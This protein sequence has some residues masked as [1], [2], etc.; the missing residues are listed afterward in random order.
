MWFRELTGFAEGEVVDVAA[1]LVVDG[2]QMT[3]TVN[4]RRFRVGRF[5]TPTLDEL[6]QRS[7]AT[8]LSGSPVSS[9]SPG[10]SLREVV[11]DVGALHADPA[12]TGALFQVA[13]QFNTLEMIS[14]D[15]T[16]EDGVDRYESDRT[17]GPA[18]AVACG[19]G[20]IY[21]N[22][23]V[24]FDE[25]VGQTR[26]RQIDCLATLAQGLGVVVPMSNGYALP[27]AEL[28]D[29]VG[30]LLGSCSVAD[31]DALLG[32]LRIGLQWDTEVTRTVDGGHV[33]HAV[34]QAYCSAMPVAY[35]QHGAD[36][37]EPF[38]RLV[39]DAAYEATFHAALVNGARTGNRTLYLTM[40][41]GGVFGNDPRWILDAIERATE[42]LA[43]A[44]ALDVAIVS[45]GSPN[46]QLAPL[47]DRSG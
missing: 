44:A 45:H 24:P 17:Q 30:G 26:D 34:S 7:A 41:G 39:L 46:T 6:R 38:A 27:S 29:E 43:G 1:N 12:N 8:E 18:C 16:P 3:S 5:E 23:L 13:S 42:T 2:H 22:Y 32:R 15:V 40:V 35:S 37:W 14:P 28:L 31:R 33:G 11:A 9:A 36:R 25:G 19:A 20:T 10:S 21:R 47:L 4:G